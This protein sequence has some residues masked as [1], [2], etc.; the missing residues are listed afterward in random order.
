MS[1]QSQARTFHSTIN[2]RALLL[3]MALAAGIFVAGLVAVAL[4]N[5]PAQ[6]GTSTDVVMGPGYTEWR[7]AQA[8][9]LLSTTEVIGPGYTEW[10][11]AQA[12]A[13]SSTTEV[14]G[15]GYTEWRR[16]QNAGQ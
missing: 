12:A 13:Q 7:Q 9:A 3:A 11:Q 2:S 6:T 5:A 16:S 14:P 10:R 4:M 15:P 8:A 1:G